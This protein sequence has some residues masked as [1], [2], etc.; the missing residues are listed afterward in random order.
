[1]RLANPLVMTRDLATCSKF[2]I[3][4]SV[5]EIDI[6]TFVLVGENDDI[7]TPAIAA[8]FEK[9]F[10]RADIAVVKGADHIPMVEQPKEFNRLF[11]KFIEWV[12]DNV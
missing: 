5:G 3:T 11:R 6:P 8:E 4:D 9:M 10:P 1:M 7:I 12:I 2:N